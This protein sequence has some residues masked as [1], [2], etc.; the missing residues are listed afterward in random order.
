V[1]PK[2]KFKKTKEI[3]SDTQKCMEKLRA[4][5]MINILVKLNAY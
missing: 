3:P 1:L 2:N 5:E 4:T